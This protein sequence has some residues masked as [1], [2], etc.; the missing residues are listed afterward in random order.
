MLL[1]SNF[2]YISHY[3]NSELK[4]KVW[5][6][7]DDNKI[8][9]SIWGRS[10]KSYKWLNNCC[11]QYNDTNEWMSTGI[12]HKWTKM[13]WYDMQKKL[14]LHIKGFLIL[15]ET[16]GNVSARRINGWKYS[17]NKQLTVWAYISDLWCKE[18]FWGAWKK[19]RS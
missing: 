4:V 2:M 7:K 16:C 8:P 1:F 17:W 11:W 9:Y 18:E 15:S 13:I 10:E 3:Y 14:N 6:L 19:Y 12:L 5:N